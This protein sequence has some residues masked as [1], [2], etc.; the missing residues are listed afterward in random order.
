MAKKHGSSMKDIQPEVGKEVVKS[1]RSNKSTLDPRR[2]TARPGSMSPK[3]ATGPGIP[4]SNKSGCP[5]D[6]LPKIPIKAVSI[7][8]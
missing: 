4:P 2:H 3:Q 8:K 7:R 5:G 1:T 6:G